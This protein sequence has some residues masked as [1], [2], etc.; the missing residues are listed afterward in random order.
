MRI[1]FA[2]SKAHFDPTKSRSEHKYWG[3]SANILSRNI[4]DVLNSLGEVTYIDCW[5]KEEVDSVKDQEF[6]VFLGII[7]K[8]AEI[9]SAITASKKILWAVNSHPVFRNRQLEGFIER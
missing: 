5:T 4:Y 6:D 9:A 8:F 3:S 2:Y 7:D 1:L